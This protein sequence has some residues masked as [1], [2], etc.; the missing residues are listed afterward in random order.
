VLGLH[1]ERQGTML[2][3]WNLR[4]KAWLPTP[5]ESRRQDRL[6]RESAEE[7]AASAE[8]R[9]EQEAQARAEAERRAVDADVERE[10]MRKEIEELRRR[11]GEAE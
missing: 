2:R 11:L 5:E 9:A 10:Q 7:R 3:L 6:A 4:T 1:L 8:E